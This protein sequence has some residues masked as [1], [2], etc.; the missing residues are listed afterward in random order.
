MDGYR[1]DG[2]VT[3]RRWMVAVGSFYLLL[4]LRLLPPINGPMIEAV[5][6]DALYTAGDLEPG[7]AV[8]SFVLDWMGTFGTSLLPL[9]AI[10]LMA[11]R[12]SSRNR[13]LVHLVIWHELTAGVVA[14]AWY[15][16]RGYVSTGFYLGFIVLHLVIVGTGIRALR[17]TAPAVLTAAAAGGVTATAPSGPV[18]APSRRSAGRPGGRSRP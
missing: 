18:L 4:G 8:F 15:I 10:L 6:V 12:D 16:G 14:D 2:E 3:M 17:R 11:A 9:G 1:T 7:T 13:L 5:G